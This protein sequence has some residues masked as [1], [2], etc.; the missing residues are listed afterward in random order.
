MWQIDGGKDC[1]LTWG[2]LMD[3]AKAMNFAVM[4]ETRFI[5]RSQQRS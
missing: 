1:V 5:M 3:I 2:G 4:V